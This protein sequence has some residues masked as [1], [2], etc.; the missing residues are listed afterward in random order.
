MDLDALKALVGEPVSYERV[1]EH[2]QV[3]IPE[4]YNLAGDTVLRQVDGGNGEAVA[5]VAESADGIIKRFTYAELAE[6]SSRLSQMLQELGVTRGTVVACYL[7]AGLEAALTYLAVFRLGGIVAPLSQLYG[8]DT[9]IH[10]LVDSG[11]PILI[12]ESELWARIADQKSRC[13][14]LATVV[15]TD[16]NGE[17][18]IIDFNQYQQMPGDEHVEQ[19]RAESAALLLYTSGSTG[20]PKGIL[21][22]HRIL[23]GYLASVSLFY[24][25]D[26]NKP[27]RVLWTPSDWSWV[28]GI[29]NVMLTGWFFGQ[30][31][32]A[33]RAR[34]SAEGSFELMARHG[35]THCFLTP[36]ALKR[37]AAIEDPY[38]RWPDLAIRAIGTGGEPLPSAILAWGDQ[39]L[40]V[41]IN[42]FYGL[43]EV[44]H[45]IGNCRSLYP[46]RPGSMGKAYPGHVVA[47]I[48]QAGNPLPD[49]EIGEI[50]ARDDDPTLLL[51]YW[52]QLGRTASMRVGRWVRTG[53]LG[54]RD[55][56]GYFWYH[57]RNDDLI[58]SAGYRIG[59]AEVEDALVEH[60]AIDEAAV[61]GSP[62][63]DRGQVVK[64]FVRLAAGY[65]PGADL[66]KEIQMHVK[67]C[68]AAYKYPRK[69]EFVKD[70]PLTSTGKINRKALRLKETA[71]NSN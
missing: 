9:V 24:E 7:G 51:G 69:I 11:A 34:F 23:R 39:I 57:G 70:F 8:P 54:Y 15:L 41:P 1:I 22:S 4:Y 36:T 52:N 53:D 17:K 66:E 38:G 26:M 13:P 40:N 46:V 33:S 43:T 18:D 48:D 3:R 20:M 50:A 2:F 19:T 37:M 45:L 68:L 65:E 35:V 61:V 58:K 60:P 21:H 6:R 67:S 49:G 27:G 30:T 71:E 44:N 32:V 25:L 10:A 42:E 31:V 55:S 64:A 62:D 28:A 16:A 63:P 12:S 14:A 47:I 56:D 59:P 29:F 5:L